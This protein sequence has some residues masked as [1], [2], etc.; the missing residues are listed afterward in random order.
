MSDESLDLLLNVLLG[1]NTVS[2]FES[3]MDTIEHALEGVDKKSIDLAH[4]FANVLDKRLKQLDTQFAKSK[5]QIDAMKQSADKLGAIS[6]TMFV[7]GSAIVGGL[8]LAAKKE[9][10][11]VIE[12]GGKVDAVTIRWIAA[13]ERITASQQKIGKSA[14]AAVLPLLE[15]V[16]GLAEDAADFVDK[17]PDLVSAALNIGVWTAGIGAIGVAVSKGIK[18]AADIKY[19]AATA[20]F[21][22]DAAAMNTAAATMFE[23]AL[24][25]QGG[26]S[27][28]IGYGAAGG[29][30]GPAAAPTAAGAGGGAAIGSVASAALLI[31]APVIGANIAKFVGNAFQRAAGMEESSWADILDTAKQAMMLPTKLALLGLVEAG[32]VSEETGAKVNNFQ[33]E[34][35]GLGETTD[36][37]A[38]ETSKF[39]SNLKD[40]AAAAKKMADLVN[41]NLKAE[42]KYTADRED[43]LTESS[44]SLEDSNRKLDKDLRGIADSLASNIRKINTGLKST[45]Q[46]LSSNF[47][48]E[49]VK[50]ERE[51]QSQRA[52]IITSGNDEVKNIQQQAKKDLEDLEREHASTLTG[53]IANRDALGI[54]NENNA[55]AEKQADIKQNAAESAAQARANTQAQLAEAARNYEEQR[56]QRQAEYIKQKEEAKVKAA[57]DIAEARAQATEERKKAM[58]A[59]AEEKAEI[60]RNRADKLADLRKGF[61]RE[62]NERVTAVYNEIAELKGALNA[63]MLM[64][65]TYQNQILADTTAHMQSMRN[66]QQTG[67]ATKPSN[68]L[69]TN[70]SFNG[71]S[72]GAGGSPTHDYSGYAYTGMY[73]MAQDGQREYVLSGSATRAAEQMV[74]GQ[75]NQQVLLSGLAGMQNS[76]QQYIDNASY[77]GVTVA[78]QRKLRQQSRRESISVMRDVFKR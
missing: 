48:N 44:R 26:G 59:N 53:L 62:R 38:E 30:I 20:Q 2:K 43:I 13:N 45:L 35:F 55:Y 54:V 67:V 19:L 31:A 68:T 11:R 75:L 57:A 17:N 78:D 40:E 23:A 73:A 41:D 39:I 52:D 58:E 72:A 8:Y 63:E 1:S 3:G 29:L 18:L 51:Y 12:A 37:A 66:V 28:K 69:H 33:N 64:R 14:E 10:D 49:N 42:R 6:Q 15:K 9:A 5:K 27:A 24:L 61:D 65:R 60:E 34:L 46:E 71:A 47:T 70:N 4:T 16:A 32:V 77:S 76:S 25:M 21:T 50:A 36:K 22:I 7:A 74:G 56:A